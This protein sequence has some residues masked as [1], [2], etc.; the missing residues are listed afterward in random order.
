[1]ILT[2]DVR[3]LEARHTLQLDRGLAAIDRNEGVATRSGDIVVR[4]QVIERV[5]LDEQVILARDEVLDDVLA[6]GLPLVKLEDVVAG[7]ADHRVVAGAADEGVVAGPSLHDGPATAAD[8]LGIRRSP[9]QGEMAADRDFLVYTAALGTC[10]TVASIVVMTIPVVVMMVL[11][12]VV[13]AV[14]AVR[15]VAPAA[16]PEIQYTAADRGLTKRAAHR[17]LALLIDRGALATE[18]DGVNTAG[19]GLPDLAAVAQSQGIVAA[20]DDD[21]AFAR[22]VD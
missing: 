4:L 5:A 18:I 20:A 22:D 13:A 6:A 14:L 1:V 8:E 7:A 17:G 21:P 11:V 16:H 2:R 15:D 19:A 9:L 10:E 12:V 3:S